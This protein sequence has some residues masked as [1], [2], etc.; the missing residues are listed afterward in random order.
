M[1]APT[2]AHE[3]VLIV[4]GLTKAFG[5][6]TAVDGV[7]FELERATVLGVIGPNGSGKTTL[8]NLLTAV[9]PPDAG[10]ALI[11]SQR[12]TGVRPHRVAGMG[13][14]RTFQTPHVFRTLTAFQNMQVPML[15]AGSGS[16]EHRSRAYE[17][18]E[19]VHL[20]DFA[21]VPASE[22]SGG[23]QKLLEFA[24]AL[25]TRPKV[26]L[27]DEPFAGVHPEVQRLMRERI[28]Q[29]RDKEGTSFVVVS[30]ETPELLTISQQLLCMDS[31]SVIA[32]GEPGQ[33]VENQR[34]VEAYLGDAGLPEVG[35][36]EASR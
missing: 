32:Y 36:V 30:H 24:R 2:T 33:V 14:A 25:M 8:V 11:S 27:M 18:L 35:T 5:G 12:I 9:Y 13:M 10:E 16:D 7:S 23:Q 1:N 3:P 4:R 15:H 19:F 20:R 28:T 29:M 34:V 21:E 6:V 31:G 26:V 17:L 22:L